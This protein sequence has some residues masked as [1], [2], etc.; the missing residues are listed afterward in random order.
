LTFWKVTSGVVGGAAALLSVFWIGYEVGKLQGDCPNRSAVSTACENNNRIIVISLKGK[1][2]Q[3][4]I[5]VRKLLNIRGCN[6]TGPIPPGKEIL[7]SRSDIRYF[8][9][10]DFNDAKLIADYITRETGI[11]FAIRN[12]QELSHKVPRGQLELWLN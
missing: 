9:K 2:D 5:E 3:R 6:A 10:T 8:H 12:I 4:G 1:S 11:V 7:L